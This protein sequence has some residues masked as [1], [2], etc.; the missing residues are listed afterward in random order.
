MS[1]RIKIYSPNA[2]LAFSPPH[3]FPIINTALV[4]SCLL[5]IRM[6]SILHFQLFWVM[7]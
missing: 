7:L 3:I 5:Y 1:Q 4:N 2:Y 6:S